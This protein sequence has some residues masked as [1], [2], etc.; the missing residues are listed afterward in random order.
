M[1]H[2]YYFPK[3]RKKTAIF[4]VL[5]FII[6]FCFA[7]I[8]S[9]SNGTWLVF[10]TGYDAAGHLSKV[11]LILEFWPD[12]D[13]GYVWYG[14]MPLFK[15]YTPIPEYSYAL[16]SA[17]TGCSIQF[18]IIFTFFMGI[19]F[20]GI[21]LYLS[22]FACTTDY[23]ASLIAAFLA[24]SSSIFWGWGIIGG[25]YPRVTAI[26]ML[27]MMLYFLIIYAKNQANDSEIE[28]RKIYFAL[29][30]ALFITLV[31]HSL[32]GIVAI[33]TCLAFSMFCIKRWKSKFMIFLKILFPALLLSAWFY[34]PFLQG[35][36]SLYRESLVPDPAGHSP[37]GWQPMTVW[38]IIYFLLSLKNYAK[39]GSDM[40][41]MAPSILPLTLVLLVL[42]SI[43]LRH[44]K[45]DSSNNYCFKVVASIGMASIL[46]NM[47]IFM[48][49]DNSY[50]FFLFLSLPIICGILS[51]YVL[52]F[53]F[54][55]HHRQQTLIKR[56]VKIFLL[57][58]IISTTFIAYPINRIS[59][60]VHEGKIQNN[61]GYDHV[62]RLLLD[63]TN[64]TNYRF[65]IPSDMVA[66]WFNSKYP[67]VPQTRGYYAQGIVNPNWIFWFEVA[68]WG[69]GTTVRGYN[70]SYF[71]T[72]FLLDWMAVKWFVVYDPYNHTKF[73]HE[74]DY[75]L[76]LGNNDTKIYG[77][78]YKNATPVI[79]ATN[80][81]A[82]LI[83]GKAAESYN[84][85]FHGL[86]YSDYDSRSV[87]PILGREYID[88][89]SLDEIE[90][91]DAVILYGY[92]FHNRI[93]AYELLEK[94]VNQGGGLIIETGYSPESSASDIPMPSPVN[95]TKW[96]SFGT[97]WNFSYIAS[98]VTDG[99]NFT[100]FSPAIYG[101]AS[102]S[103]SG[104]FNESIRSGA[105][106]IVWNNG[107][108]VVV[109]WEYGKG[110][111]VWC[112]LNIPHH[113]VYYK[114]SMESFFFSKMI[115]WVSRASEKVATKT[116]YEVERTNPKEV[117]VKIRN[118][119]TGV[120]FKEFY[121]ENWHAYLIASNR[122]TECQIYSTGP[123]FMYIQVPEGVNPPFKV[124]FEHQKS[125][126][127]WG[128]SILSL[129]SICVLT[130]YCFS[131]AILS[132]LLSLFVIA[133]RKIRKR[134]GDWWWRE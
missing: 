59:L 81:P 1:K 82:I 3:T 125:L 132:R 33:L 80:A 86:S 134:I 65:G 76:I 45:V 54:F 124:V 122:K 15:W 120:L 21:M 102:W 64:Q 18:S 63:D 62:Q 104:S 12:C 133:G 8:L 94:Y 5:S 29:E 52:D 60:I 42:A 40:Y 131:P 36:E 41:S 38:Q 89:Y 88:D 31:S 91:F 108:P 61:Y 13:W 58:G 119:A 100:S 43:K 14:G 23:L 26:A 71:E 98:P 92:N 24:V 66:S 72:K 114:N 32:I 10:P 68:V 35:K 49:A 103:F 46:L 22:V 121:I 17:I 30:L 97:S 48:G 95:R 79:S 115:D 111:V 110:R 106:P 19:I 130:I 50:F 4:H 123:G 109:A 78:I 55:S 67:K 90:R 84:P 77:F 75:S 73:S 87:I 126:V 101:N 28:Q 70:A 99:I 117:I 105:R 83:I 128:S 127:E 51:N 25:M 129:T 39:P 11:K 96:T 37:S 7:L 34:I 16:F 85:I 9:L 93:R 118:A 56:A 2:N 69:H 6:I 53:N 57:V 47:Y 27:S 20:T 44:R 112:G 116:S 74:P 113:I 107:R